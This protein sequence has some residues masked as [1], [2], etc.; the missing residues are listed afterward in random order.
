MNPNLDMFK[1]LWL[2][3]NFYVL[4]SIQLIHKGSSAKIIQH[5]L[6]TTHNLTHETSL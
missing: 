6:R 4:L 5:L 1:V 2:P 3:N